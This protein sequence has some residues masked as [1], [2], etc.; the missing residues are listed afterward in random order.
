[1]FFM[2]ACCEERSELMAFSW[3][4]CRF[5]SIHTTDMLSMGCSKPRTEH[6][7]GPE[8]SHPCLMWGSSKGQPML[9]NSLSAW[10]RLSQ[11][12]IAFWSFSHLIFLPAFIGFRPASRSG[13][14][15]YLL[16]L[17]LLSSLSFTGMSL[18]NCLRLLIL[19]KCLFLSG[20]ELTY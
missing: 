18:N 13:G 5:S 9:G 8:P 19:L 11:N 7:G 10:L 1:M 4:T 15:P 14:S 6:G 3:S 2:T 20:T 17:P 12:C 16:L